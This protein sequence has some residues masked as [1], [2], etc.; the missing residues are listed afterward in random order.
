MEVRLPKI[1]EKVQG[2]FRASPALAGATL[3]TT[4]VELA[5]DPERRV[6]WVCCAGHARTTTARQFLAIEG[7]GC[8]VCQKSVTD[9]DGKAKVLEVIALNKGTLLD[10]NFEYVNRFTKVQLQCV[11]GHKFSLTPSELLNKNRW[12]P[13]CKERTG[14]KATRR[15]LETLLDCTLPGPTRGISWMTERTGRD[16]ELD[17]FNSSV[18]I[19]G[20][21]VPV[22]F[23]YQGEQHYRKMHW[24]NDEDF[25]DMQERDRLKREACLVAGV[26]LLEVPYFKEGSTFDQQLRQVKQLLADENISFVD[27][28]V[29]AVVPKSDPGKISELKETLAARG[30]ELRS[31]VFNGVHGK[32]TVYCEKHDHTWDAMYSELNPKSR[33]PSYKLRKP[34]GC[35]HCG[36][37]VTRAALSARHKRVREE[38]AALKTLGEATVQVP[39]VP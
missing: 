3:K 9:P 7:I 32:L 19:N 25:A 38:K 39:A 27:K 18:T 8:G 37:I 36:R 31:E 33:G 14:E 5:Q 30:L 11:D 2:V 21:A 29:P 6:H 12:C 13:T 34:T 4:L 17:G 28:F 26:R 10:K 20:T 1:F 23:E 16:L 15:I 22:A 35:I 24:H